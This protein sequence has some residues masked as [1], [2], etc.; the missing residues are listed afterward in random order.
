M[1]KNKGK[2]GLS[3]YVR[4]P[5]TEDRRITMIGETAMKGGKIAFCVD[6]LPGQADRYI[7]KLLTKYP[8]LQVVQRFK[9]PTPG[10]ESVIVTRLE[11]PAS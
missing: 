8:Q 3:S 1:G 4:I 9:G 10:V 2:K 6:D 7:E 11:E 5:M